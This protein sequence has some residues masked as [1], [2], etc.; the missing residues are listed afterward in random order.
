MY[1]ENCSPLGHVTER[2]SLGSPRTVFPDHHLLRHSHLHAQLIEDET[3]RVIEQTMPFP[4]E[5][6]DTIPVVMSHC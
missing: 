5:L 4:A 6:H 1:A 3:R 2:G